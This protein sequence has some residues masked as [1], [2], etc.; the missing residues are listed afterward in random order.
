MIVPSTPL[1]IA[2]RGASAYAAEHTFSAYDMAIAM[3]A[4][5]LEVDVR[6]TADTVP[7]VVHDRTLWR[8]AIDP[9][10]VAEVTMADLDR[11]D[12]SVRP[13]TLEQVFER[14]GD[15]TRYLLDLKAPRSPVERVVLATAADAGLCDRIQIQSFSRAGIR[16][17]RRLDPSISCAQ[18]YPPYTPKRASL[19]D[20]GRV[21]AFADAI[22][23]H[24]SSVDPA[25][26]VAAHAQ[27]L[28]VQPY[29]V[30]D[31]AEIA[32]LLALGVDG[33]ITDRPDLARTEIDGGAR[34]RSAA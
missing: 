24:S 34:K 22:G 20:L 9:R 6:L 31:P 7:V 1:A 28:R 4:D 14:Y 5:V 17:A 26:V 27:G 29:T 15:E 21:K 10:A 8:T 33:I 23:P 13:L 2:H 25:L 16:R 11:L 3:G 18:L 32:R 30:N 12:P 19:H